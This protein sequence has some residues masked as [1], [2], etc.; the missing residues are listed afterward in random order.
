MFGCYLQSIYG[1]GT[2][3][4]EI[5]SRRLYSLVECKNTTESYD[6]LLCR[7]AINS[8]KNRN[9]LILKQILQF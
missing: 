3:V 9:G 1:S 6:K 7:C 2:I 5:R 4:I 8:R